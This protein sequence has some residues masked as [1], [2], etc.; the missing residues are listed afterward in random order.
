MMQRDEFFVGVESMSW[1][2]CELEMTYCNQRTGLPALAEVL[3]LE[4]MSNL[5]N[6]LSTW[7]IWKPIWAHDDN[8]L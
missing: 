4:K 1:L 6:I 5:M 2:L 7:I 8:F 3:Q